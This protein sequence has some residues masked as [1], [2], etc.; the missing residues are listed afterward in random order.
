MIQGAITTAPTSE[1][2]KDLLKK[3]EEELKDRMQS[4]E[5]KVDK[6]SSIP[7]SLRSPGL[8]T[9]DFG[10]ELTDRGLKDSLE[11]NEI[12][13]KKHNNEKGMREI[14]TRIADIEDRLPEFKGLTSWDV[15]VT[16]VPTTATLDDVILKLNE[17]IKVNR[18]F[19]RL[20]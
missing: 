10:A 8:Q 16:L 14:L 9:N 18:R 11:F 19:D 3:I 17:L 7:T 12:I 15:P 5:G 1:S 20:R 13:T 2:D 4:L 6:A